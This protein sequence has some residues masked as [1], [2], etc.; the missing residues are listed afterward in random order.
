MTSQLCLTYPVSVQVV[1]CDLVC[2]LRPLEI[3]SEKTPLQNMPEEQVE[4]ILGAIL[5]QD[6]MCM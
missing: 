1:S 5:I 4:A 6:S 2:S 3:G